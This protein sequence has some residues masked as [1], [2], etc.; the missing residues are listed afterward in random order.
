MFYEEDS[1]ILITGSKD[2]SIKFWK[3]PERWT[4]EEVENFEENE[5]KVIDSDL[6]S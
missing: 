6:D 1:R 5:I 2:R 3:L 4:S